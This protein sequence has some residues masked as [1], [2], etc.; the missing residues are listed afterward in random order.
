MARIERVADPVE[1]A[2]FGTFWVD[3]EIAAVALLAFRRVGWDTTRFVI[4]K[5]GQAVTDASVAGLI[6]SIG[7]WGLGSRLSGDFFAYI[8]GGVTLGAFVGLAICAVS[9]YARVTGGN[10]RTLVLMIAVLIFAQAVF[11]LEPQV[12]APPTGG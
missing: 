12:W 10:R 5:A 3:F 9:L 11:Y 6:V 8:G 1:I 4:A 7:V 2:R